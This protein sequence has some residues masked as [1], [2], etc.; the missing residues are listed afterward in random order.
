MW[1]LKM[2]SSAKTLSPRRKLSFSFSHTGDVAESANRTAAPEGPRPDSSA[3]GTRFRSLRTSS[4][5]SPMIL[6]VCMAGDCVIYGHWSDRSKPRRVQSKMSFAKKG[7]WCVPVNDLSPVF[8]T[9]LKTTPA[10]VHTLRSDRSVIKTRS[11]I[12]P[13]VGYP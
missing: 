2:K 8:S 13:K 1:D 9:D 4:A 12:G 11:E 6:D 3:R 7:L 10:R 5:A